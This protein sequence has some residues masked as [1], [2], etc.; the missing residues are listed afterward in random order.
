M[1]RN[2]PESEKNPHMR[3]LHGFWSTESVQNDREN[4]NIFNFFSIRSR[5]TG[6]YFNQ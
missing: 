3:K 5:S 4:W 6:Q 1:D 2:G